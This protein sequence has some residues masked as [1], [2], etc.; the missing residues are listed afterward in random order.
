MSLLTVGISSKAVGSTGSV[1]LPSCCLWMMRLMS[2][3]GALVLCRCEGQ[4]ATHDAEA[5]AANHMR[6]V[7]NI[8][9]CGKYIPRR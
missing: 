6:T 2:M 9:V 5:H 3:L 4:A 7:I 1:A 8:I